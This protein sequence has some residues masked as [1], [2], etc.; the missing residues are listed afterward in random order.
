MDH[1][2]CAGA[3]CDTATSDIEV[4]FRGAPS[5]EPGTSSFR[6]WP[7]ARFVASDHPRNDGDMT[8]FA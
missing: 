1:M 4:S 8:N 3:M 6:V 5:R 7:S 2:A